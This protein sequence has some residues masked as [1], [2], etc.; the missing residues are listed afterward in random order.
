MNRASFFRTWKSGIILLAAALLV[1]AF[2]TQPLASTHA[3]LLFAALVF[4]ATF[5]RLDAGDASIGFEAAIAFDALIVFHSPSVAFVAMFVG[6][7]LHA[8]YDW[9]AQRVFRLDS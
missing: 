3:A 1:F 9:I 5:L 2:V 6:S 8:A 4:V 7:A